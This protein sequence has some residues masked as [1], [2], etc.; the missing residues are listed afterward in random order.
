MMP[1]LKEII[2]KISA[3]LLNQIIEEISKTNGGHNEK[4]ELD[5]DVTNEAI[6]SFINNV[7][8]AKYVF[9][10]YHLNENTPRSRL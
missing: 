5:V 8:C 1:I 4:I 2:K 3:D 7:T 10:K 6:S 9:D